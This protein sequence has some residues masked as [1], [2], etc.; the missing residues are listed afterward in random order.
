MSQVIN[1][2]QDEIAAR[3]GITVRVFG[4]GAKMSP[5]EAASTESFKEWN[6]DFVIIISPIQAMP[7]SG[8]DRRSGP[9]DFG[10]NAGT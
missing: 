7:L 1:L 3:E 5:T 4:T 6:A 8:P 10:K 9:K 2:I